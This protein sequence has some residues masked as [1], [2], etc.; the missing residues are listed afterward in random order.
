VYINDELLTERT[1]IWQHA[2]LKESLQLQIDPGKY[3]LSFELLDDSNA[4]M[5]VDN[6]RVTQG[7]AGIKKGRILRVHDEVA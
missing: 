3:V 7:P 5:N 2:Y 4:E 1:F 6:V